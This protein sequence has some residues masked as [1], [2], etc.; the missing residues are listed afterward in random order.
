MET[1]ALL[2]ECKDVA[3][4]LQLRSEQVKFNKSLCTLLATTYSRSLNGAV[5]IRDLSA[6]ETTVTELR[7]IL[8]CGEM[9]VAQWS[10][11]NWWKSLISS[12]DSASIQKKVFLHL[13]EFLFCVKVLMLN[14]NDVVAPYS[15]DLLTKDVEVASLFDLESLLRILEM[16]RTSL[17][18]G[19]ESKLVDHVL[20][21]IRATS[22]GHVHLLSIEYDDVKREQIL[23]HGAFGAV[24]KCEY[25]GVPAAAKVFVVSNR[26]LADK[27][28]K[29]ADLLARLR[30]PNVVQFVG[31][32]VKGGEHLIVSE[33]MSMDLRKYL[34]ENVHED[35]S[36]PPL[37]LLLAVDIMLQVAE[38]MKYLHE[39]MVMHRDLK[40]N[41]VLINIVETQ[42]SRLPSSLQVKITDFGLSKL[43]LNNSRFT[44]RQMGATPWRAPEV[45]ED[46]E[47]TEKYTNA[48]DVYSFA[49]VFFEVLTGEVPFANIPR[50]QVLPSIRR[51]E[52]PTLPSEEYCP[53]HLSAII[54]M[55]W[56][57]RA[58]DR[59]K[60]SEICRKLMEVKGRIMFQSYPNPSPYKPQKC[61]ND[62]GYTGSIIAMGNTEK[63]CQGSGRIANMT[64]STPSDLLTGTNRL[65]GEIQEL[66]PSPQH[67][68]KPVGELACQIQQLS[69]VVHDTH[70]L[71][72][73]TRNLMYNT[74]KLV[75]NDVLSVTTLKHSLILNS[76]RWQ[77]PRIVL[78]TTQDA[79][80]KQKL[81]TKLVPGM[82]VVQLHLLCEY[83]GQQHIVEGQ[84]SCQVI[85]EDEDWK[86]VHKLVQE[87]LKWVLLAVRVGAHI[88]MGLG[89][90]VPNRNLEY[91]KAVVALGEGVLKDSPIDWATV[92]PGKLVRD[93]ASTSRT[94]ETM[95]AELWLLNFLKGK[96]I[97]NKFGLQR[98]LYKGR[99]ELRWI[100]RKHFDQGMRVGELDGFPC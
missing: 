73:D 31:Y 80:F 1:D 66:D 76:S 95:S 87:R 5:Y 8:S 27:V 33:L 71:M 79:S 40:A 88:K 44:T 3:R 23:G 9:L 92:T 11:K 97:L 90:M 67:Q 56:A 2:M 57:T 14:C 42:D 25:L 7:R 53:A 77:V 35:Q 78:F 17:P 82:K 51:E 81:I 41:N 20:E 48:A 24:F 34:D 43:N 36:R 18:R 100:C 84:A 32:V 85:I 46:E 50:S 63:W 47:N 58:E 26:T 83:K 74:H 98:V 55:C 4:T 21:N 52:R 69:T 54:K 59:P 94:A 72:Y 39:S 19:D 68:D 49:L 28:K 62:S 30:H 38:A 6:C 37:P 86:N 96:D 99:G 75:K 22:P 65:Q 13:D 10:D 91:G 16:Y 89:N 12:S 70:N 29:E 64:I 60:F 93:E 45:F 61:T 15:S